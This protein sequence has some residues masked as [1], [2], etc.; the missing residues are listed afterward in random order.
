MSD[1]VPT[2]DTDMQRAGVRDSASLG[3][4]QQTPPKRLQTTAD[5]ANNIAAN[6]EQRYRQEID[7]LRS[8]LLAVEQER[9]KLQQENTQLHEELA[10]NRTQIVDLQKNVGQL[11]ADFAAGKQEMAAMKQSVE[12][13]LQQHAGAMAA[14]APCAPC[15]TTDPARTTPVSDPAT[16]GSPKTAPP[17]RTYASAVAAAA[18]SAPRKT[19]K[20]PHQ[21]PNKTRRDPPRAS[22]GPERAPPRPQGNRALPSQEELLDKLARMNNVILRGV[23]GCAVRETNTVVR[24]LL[25]A[26]GVDLP[27]GVRFIRLGSAART[28]AD[29][30]CEGPVKALCYEPRAAMELMR[31]VERH[32][33][34]II[35]AHTDLSVQERADKA[36]RRRMNDVWDSYKAEGY[37]LT[38]VDGTQLFYWKEGARDW[39]PALP[40]PPAAPGS[41]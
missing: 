40:N 32:C 14:L 18:P 33:E 20:G 6:E 12:T 25:T 35:T 19:G 21:G 7:E 34:G 1:Y 17:T 2:A 10:R 28:G 29:K 16:Q 37:S 26:E 41:G 27:R 13:L 24:A 36:A 39:A 38:W 30:A 4:D 31:Q 11:Q 8:Q 3:V 5:R 22:R 23:K 9:D 15:P